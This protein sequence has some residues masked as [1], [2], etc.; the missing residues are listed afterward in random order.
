ME[1]VNSHTHPHPLDPAS[2]FLFSTN[3]F[4][5]RYSFQQEELYLKMIDVIFSKVNCKLLCETGMF[6]VQVKFVRFC[7]CMSS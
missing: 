4:I 1:K 5:L 3:A 2:Y 7:V 6:F